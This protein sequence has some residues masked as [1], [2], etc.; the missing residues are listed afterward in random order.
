MGCEQ[1]EQV[2]DLAPEG[3]LCAGGG[4][5]K[6]VFEFGEELLDPL[7]LR[8][9]PAI[10]ARRVQGRAVG[11][12]EPEPCPCGADCGGLVAAEVVQE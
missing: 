11:R 2:A 7:A 4:F 6:Q 1:G 9:L 3:L 5:A 12:Q 10:A 8:R